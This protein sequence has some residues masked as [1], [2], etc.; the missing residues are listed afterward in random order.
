MEASRWMFDLHIDLRVIGG[1][2]DR[3]LKIHS[4]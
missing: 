4:H 3:I 1:A 2:E